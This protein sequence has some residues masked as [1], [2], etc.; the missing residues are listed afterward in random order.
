[1]R[2]SIGAGPGTR[3]LTI[4]ATTVPVSRKT[5]AAYPFLGARAASCHVLPPSEVRKVVMGAGPGLNT[6]APWVASPNEAET[7]LQALPGVAPRAAVVGVV[8]AGGP[9]MGLRYRTP[10]TSVPAAATPIQAS[11][12]RLRSSRTSTASGYG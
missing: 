1:M 9:R 2:V 11:A 12:R 5:A 10:A 4:C 6:I 3:L 7:S 8:V